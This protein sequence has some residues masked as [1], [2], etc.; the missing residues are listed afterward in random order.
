MFI[1]NDD[2]GEASVPAQAPVTDPNAPQGYVEA[3]YFF[4]YSWIFILTPWLLAPLVLQYWISGGTFENTTNT[5]NFGAQHLQ[6]N[7]WI[8]LNSMFDLG[9]IWTLA[10][11][12]IHRTPPTWTVDKIQPYPIWLNDLSLVLLGCV[13]VAV[14][15][16]NSLLH[17]QFMAIALVVVACF[18]CVHLSYYFGNCSHP[19]SAR[20][21]VFYGIV[22]AVTPVVFSYFYPKIVNSYVLMIIAVTS[23]CLYHPIA[24]EN[25]FS[26]TSTLIRETEAEMDFLKTVPNKNVIIVCDRPVD[27]TA[28]GYGAITFT[29]A[30][31]HY[32]EINAEFNQH[33]Y[34]ILVMQRVGY[35]TNWPLADNRFDA[36]YNLKI[37]KQQQ[38][39]GSDDSQT[40]G[41]YIR[42]SWV[43]GITP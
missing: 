39:S 28:L 36:P 27:F 12:V 21:F 4:K 32:N 22:L 26:N 33:L 35:T 42:I 40:G 9:R 17:R 16:R 2:A 30:N 1:A 41:C 31:E 29:Y 25:R 8:A 14:I 37:V 34:T 24:V 6:D 5:P 10:M 19:A 3:S 43:G 20:M 18:L 13:F 23:A 7:A 15:R 38:I 11:D